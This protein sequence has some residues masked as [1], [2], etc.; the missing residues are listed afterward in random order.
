MAGLDF[1]TQLLGGGNNG[2]QQGGS[3]DINAAMSDPRVALGIG[4]LSTRTPQEG[5]AQGMGLLSKQSEVK[6]QQKMDELERLYKTAQI[7]HLDD[8]STS[9]GKLIAERDSLAPNDPKRALYDAQIQKENTISNPYVMGPNPYQQIQLQNQEE[10]R[11][12]KRDQAILAAEEKRNNNLSGQAEK[13]AKAIESSGIGDIHGAVN[14]FENLTTGLEDI[15]GFG[16]GKILPDV[17]QDDTGK[18]I[19]QEVATIRNSILK[20]RSGGAVT[21]QESDRLLQELGDGYGK[22]DAQLRYGISNVRKM[23]ESKLGNIEAGYDPA[24][25][26]MYQQR[27]G[28]IRKSGGKAD[29]APSMS[30]TI[31]P[32]LDAEMTRRGLK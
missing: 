23:M 5:I 16:A 10:D 32:A 26:D 31:D 25:L 22:T 2:Q 6:R 11:N 7:K 4:L 24:A 21:P 18:A 13:Y 27:G 28:T 12:W 29:P 3:F 20:A 19:R 15:P 1:L 30:N 17:M 14:R 8:P 9:F